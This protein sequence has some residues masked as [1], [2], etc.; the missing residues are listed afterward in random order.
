MMF[1]LIV[2][3][4]LICTTLCAVCQKATPQ[5]Y[6][7]KFKSLAISEM[8]RTGVP[9]SITLAQGIL[10]SESGNSELVLKSNNH[11]GIKCKSNWTGPSVSHDDDMPGEC[12]RAYAHPEESFRD[13]SDFLKNSP[14]YA[15]LFDLE[16]QD[17][18]GWSTGLKKAGYAT[19]PRY[20]EILIANIEKYQLNQYTI[21]GLLEGVAAEDLRTLRSEQ[22]KPENLITPSVE[23]ETVDDLIML[24]VHNLK[25]VRAKAGMSLLAIAS[26]FNVRLARLLEWNEL[27]ND[28]ILPKSQLIFL[29][30][31]H[32]EGT[33]ETLTVLTA[34]S[35]YDIAQD[36][37][38]MVS[39]LSRF[40]N[41]QKHD[42]IPAGTV[43]YLKK[44]IHQNIAKEAAP[45]SPDQTAYH[46][47]QP[48][49]G[50]FAIS[51]KYGITID[52]I[53][54]WNRLP[55]DQIQIGQKLIVAQ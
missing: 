47:V 23:P 13:H 18:E 6:I 51:K 38:L 36:N 49:E 19:N 32:A 37:G 45:E 48:K 33:Q 30:K 35:L 20:A 24:K 43:L 5:Q 28:G 7:E 25:A 9:A 10:E 26:R 1:K 27:D 42:M 16:P 46:I 8:K 14:R 41:L 17:Y 50:L 12:F 40:N 15:S 34:R 29:S 53:K 11:F 2:C 44:D 22:M 3:L 31:K 52:Q 4:S 54:E 21:D 39:S 55:G